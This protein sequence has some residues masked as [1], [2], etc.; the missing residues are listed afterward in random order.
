[1]LHPAIIPTLVA[2]LKSEQDTQT[3]DGIM[4]ALNSSIWKNEVA[5]E[6]AVEIRGAFDSAETSDLVVATILLEQLGFFH[7]SIQL[8]DVADGLI[9]LIER[10]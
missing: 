6:V 5:Q 3:R 8:D 1:M 9:T 7:A 2:E 10:R 4:D